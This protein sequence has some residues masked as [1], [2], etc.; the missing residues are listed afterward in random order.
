MSGARAGDIDAAGQRIE[1]LLD[2]IAAES[3]AVAG[4]AE[5]LVTELVALYGSGLR[6]LLEVIQGATAD[7]AAVLRALAD[8]ELLAGLFVLHDLHPVDVRTRVQEALDGVRPYLGSHGGDVELLGVDEGV[9][10]LR[11]SGSCDGCPSSSMTLQY[12]VEGAVRRAAPEVAAI[13]VDGA[14]APGHAPTLI[15]VESLTSGGPARST[16]EPGWSRL[17]VPVVGAGEVAGLDVDGTALV[18]CRLGD[19]LYAYRDRCAACSGS[20]RAGP[21]RGD[22]LTCPA[23]GRRYDVRLAGR[24]LDGDGALDPVPLVEDADGVRAAL[25]AVAPQ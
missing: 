23:C 22:E 6:R 4:V 21:L 8:D 12:A 16:D 10:R 25:G 17:P 1:R 11:L 7:S 14:G 15:P 24:A 9:V 3:P 5:Q 2:E 18:L 13:Q 19:R 20:L